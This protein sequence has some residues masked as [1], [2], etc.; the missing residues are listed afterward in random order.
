MKTA[1]LLVDIQND[2]LPG[3]ALAVP[4]GDAIIPIINRLM[5]EFDWVFATQDWH[6]A[7]HKS[8]AATHNK[9][10]GTLISLN[11]IDQILWPTHCVQGTSGAALCSQLNRA[12]ISKIIYKG[13]DPE[14]DS[15]SA[16]FDNNHKKATG[17]EALLRAALIDTPHYCRPC[18]RLLRSLY[19]ARCH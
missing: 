16:F 1:L 4:Q 8:F 7:G 12:K 3:G 10:V 17:L 19:R 11:G 15:Y 5:K 2:F 14:I 13:T 18:N 6:P 9:P